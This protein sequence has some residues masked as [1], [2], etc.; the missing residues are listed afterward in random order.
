MQVIYVITYLDLIRNVPLEPKKHSTLAN[1]IM[2]SILE[3]S[4]LLFWLN[5]F[6]TLEIK[7]KDTYV[8]YI[9]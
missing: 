7:I 1:K 6:A 9:A 5:T 4:D 8:R 3:F 2:S